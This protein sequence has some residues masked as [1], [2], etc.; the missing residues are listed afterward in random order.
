MLTYIYTCQCPLSFVIYFVLWYALCLDVLI[1]WCT[2]TYVLCALCSVLCVSWWYL[3]Y[4]CALCTL[5]LMHSV[6]W[7]VHFAPCILMMRSCALCAVYFDDA[8]MCA[9]RHVFWWC[10][11]VRSA[12][13][14]LMMCSC[15]LCTM[16]FDD[17]FM[18]AL[19]RVFWWCIHVC[20]ALCILMMHSCALCDMY[21]DDAFMSTLCHVFLW[22]INVCFALCI[23]MMHS[24]MLCAPCLI[25]SIFWCAL[26][27]DTY[28]YLACSNYKENASGFLSSQKYPPHSC[29]SSTY[30]PMSALHSSLL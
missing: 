2:V 22:C 5:Y 20:S 1:I 17:A 9:L 12:P 13:C 15:V 6:F 14:I 23:L 25:H 28:L 4:L 8:F 18:C 19:H 7:C 27:F 24:C 21:F 3:M 30:I 26:Y 29:S 16:Y 10:I 11:H